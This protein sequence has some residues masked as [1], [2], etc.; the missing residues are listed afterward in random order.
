MAMHLPKLPPLPLCLLGLLLLHPAQGNDRILSYEDVQELARMRAAEPFRDRHPAIPESIR[1]LTYD[2]IREIRFDSRRALWR[3]DRMPFQI[4]FFHPGFVNQN[5]VSIHI[6]DEDTVSAIEFSPRLFHYGPSV[7]L[8]TP[9][10][11]L[12]FSGFR[13][14]SPINRPDYLDEFLVFQ[15]ASY[16]RAV[17][18]DQRYGLSARGLAIDTASAQGEEFPFFERF[19]IVKPQ[20]DS[21]HLT[22]Y[23]LLDSQSLSGAFAFVVSPGVQTTLNVRA[24]LYFRKPVETLGIAPLTSMYWYGENSPHRYGD[25]RPEVHDSDGILLFTGSQEWLW[26]PLVNRRSVHTAYFVDES[27]KGFGLLQRDR[28]FD[29]YQDIEA[30]YHL[31]PSTWVEPTDNWGPGTVRLVE[32]PTSNEFEDNIVAF[33]TPA[34]TFAAGDTYTYAY[35]L[36]WMMSGPPQ[37]AARVVATR[38][39]DVRDKPGYK[40]FIL[41]F[42]GHQ[43]SKL[44]DDTPLETHVTSN[45]SPEPLRSFTYKNP[46]NHT[47][48]THFLVPVGDGEKP[49][50]LRAFLKND[51]QAL[52]ETWTYLLNP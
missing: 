50:E 5:Q 35:K 14:H 23:A 34:R 31:R 16:F 6:I 7:N 33:W 18:K 30:C 2:Q 43:L 22:V 12:G 48:R 52:S 26:R 8:E 25:F 49:I 42:A 24:T 41:D 3:T 40:K 27:P 19:Y 11:Q 51:D 46:F 39:A 37:P 15:G 45:L 20:H 13:V 10:E 36:H 44:D 4:Q 1:A 17:G 21:P 28:Q 32:I 9:P 29:S 47:W 38:L